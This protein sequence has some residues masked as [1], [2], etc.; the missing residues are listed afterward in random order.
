ME[1][2]AVLQEFLK[3]SRNIIITTHQKP[4]GDAMGSSLA[5]YN[6][7][8]N[9]GHQVRVISS[10]EFPAYFSYL[11]NCDEVWNYLENPSLSQIAIESAELIFC[12]D[13]N[14]L[15]RIEPLDSHIKNNK[16]A[17]IVLLDHHLHPKIEATWSLHDVKACSTC[18]L[19]YRFLSLFDA[20]YIPTKEVATCIYTGILTDT[21]S[22]SNG[23]TNKKALEI[24][25][26]LL[27]C[28][29]NIIDVQEQLNQNGREEKLRFLGN[30]L[31]R[32]TIIREDIGIGIIVVDKKDA[33]RFNLQTGDTEG[34]VNYPLSIKN[35][36]VSI[37][38]K[39]E[40]KIIKLSFRSKG[41][42]SV[43][44]ICREHFEG[45]GHRNASG[46]RSF[47]SVEQTIDKII[48]IFEKEH[49]V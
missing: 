34:L 39:Q 11:P 41:E 42:Y 9:I 30:A 21:A 48:S 45:G 35:V 10:T 37:L 43:E 22:F 5:L 14:D 36:K 3:T 17:K 33:Y 12:L 18:E 26:H 24:T 44:K 15:G 46:G 6:Y 32:N 8:Q 25:A 16:N 7:L 20:N 49:L 38:V 2:I 4:D 47:L 28:G 31:F 27:D 13:F 23:A 40:P 1:N 19:V 29:L